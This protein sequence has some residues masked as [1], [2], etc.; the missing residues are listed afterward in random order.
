[1]DLAP[2]GEPDPIASAVAAS[3]GIREQVGRPA[4]DTLLEVLAPRTLLLILDNCEHLVEACGGA[5]VAAVR[6][7][8]VPAARL[9]GAAEA[10]RERL[11]TSL[12][13]LPR[14]D[15][16]WA[17]RRAQTSD[18]RAWVAEAWAAGR[19]LSVEQAVTEALGAGAPLSTSSDC[20]GAGDQRANSP[21]APEQHPWQARAAEPRSGGGLGSG[22]P[23]GFGARLIRGRNRHLAQAFLRIPGLLPRP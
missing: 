6:G 21:R 19:A 22:T 5:S 18:G 2:L 3:I 15:R 14:A 20:A 4:R 16:D 1:V 8:A 13:A 12:A 10:L 9:F 7:R 17:V 23:V 11:G